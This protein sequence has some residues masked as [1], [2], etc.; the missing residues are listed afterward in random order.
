MLLSS[1]FLDRN[2]KFKSFQSVA[3]AFSNS[4]TFLRFQGPAARKPAILVLETP[5][6]ECSQTARDS[7]KMSPL[8]VWCLWYS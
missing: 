5:M 1:T 6:F 3:R 7:H 8:L 4:K 2:A